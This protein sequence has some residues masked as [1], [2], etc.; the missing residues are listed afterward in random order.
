MERITAVA[1]TVIKAGQFKV[2]VYHFK[3]GT[4]LP[5]LRCP[6]TLPFAHVSMYSNTMH[7]ERL[8]LPAVPDFQDINEMMNIIK[9]VPALVRLHLITE[10]KKV[11]QA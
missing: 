9:I 3:D 10:I 5:V 2:K 1:A 6:F 4:S 8:C 11:T 7:G